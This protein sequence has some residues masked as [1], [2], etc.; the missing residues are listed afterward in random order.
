MLNAET[1]VNLLRLHALQR[2]QQT[3]LTFLRDGEGDAVSLTYAEL[4]LRARAI[5]SHLRLA[6]PN[7]QRALL[8]HPPG[9][10]FAAALCGCFYAGIT[11]VP[12]YPPSSK[13]GSR[14]GDRFLRL[15]ADAQVELV[16]TDSANLGRVMLQTQKLSNLHL[17]ATD[18]PQDLPPLP[19]GEDGGEGCPLRTGADLALI[20]YTSGSTGSPKGVML[21]HAN[22]MANLRTIQYSFKLGPDTRVVS[23]LPPY[24]DMGLIGGILSALACGYPLVMMAPQHFL[25]KPLRWLQAIDHYRA[26]TSGGP[27]FAFD[28][29][30]SQIPQQALDSL[31]LSCWTLAFCGAEPVRAATLQRFGQRFGTAGF[32]ASA[33]FPCY[34]L[35]EA[36]LM[37]TAVRRGEGAH[38]VAFDSATLTVG[39]A[40]R[41]AVAHNTTTLVSC[42]HAG[43]QVGLRIVNPHTQRV[44]PAG[45]VG[46]IWLSGPSM[47]AGYWQQSEASEATFHNTIDGENGA[48]WLRTG[49]L[50][51]LHNDELFINGRLKDIIIIRGRK[52]HPPDIEELATSSH[53]ALAL[54]ACAAFAVDTDTGEAL[55]IAA[56]IR[57]EARHALDAARVVRAIK[58]AVSETMAL[59]ADV[60]LLMPGA[61]ART[62]SGK[63]SRS[64][65]REQH[66]QGLWT[67]IP[68]TD[69]PHPLPAQH[70]ASA[71]QAKLFHH[72]ANVLR[73]PVD[74]L[75][76][77][78]SLG[79]LGLDSLK[80]VELALTLEQAFQV[81]LAQ[82]PFL[83]E[84]TLDELAALL[85]ART[86][87]KETHDASSP[88]SSPLS[89]GEDVH[90]LPIEI[91]ARHPAL[92]PG[93]CVPLTPLQHAYLYAGVAQ[94]ENFVQIVYLRTPRGLDCSALAHALHAVAARFDALRM[95]F[96][97]DT[98]GWLQVI[99][100][101]ETSLQFERIDASRLM[102]EQVRARR[103]DM[104]NQM[105]SGIDLANGPLVRAV[106]FERG[107]HETGVLGLAF[108][109]LVIDALSVSIFVT[110]LQYAYA[111]A[112]MGEPD[113]APGEPVFGRWLLSMDAYAQTTAPRELDYWCQVC[114]QAPSPPPDTDATTA[115]ATDTTDNGAD[116]GAGATASP[117]GAAGQTAAP[118]RWRRQVSPGLSPTANQQLLLRYPAPLQR[119]DLFLTA[120]AQAWCALSGDDHALVLLERHGRISFGQPA[121]MLAMGW[122]VCHYP[123]RIPHQPGMS[124]IEQVNRT[125][126]LM[127]EVPGDG[128]GYG[129]LLK[130][131]RDE[132]VQQAMRALRRPR[133]KLIYRGSIDDGF[134]ADATFPVIGSESLA[135]A[136]YDAQERSGDNCHAELYVSMIRGT[137]SWTL[138]YAPKFF[139]E[140]R[141]QA[142]LNEI[143]KLISAVTTQLD[144]AP[145]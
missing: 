104:V 94:P 135:Q 14:T 46:E 39:Q 49:D 77:A 90:P 75:D 33:F 79:A 27:G 44:C 124:A 19:P 89:I 6:R 24:H 18:A 8:L 59:S 111:Q 40:L 96:V 37:A 15:V 54:N 52:H 120:L 92:Q 87:D 63:I 22:L 137:V 106:L 110:A 126:R 1:L 17:L 71:T 62:T 35:A 133:L 72:I 57:R 136:Y 138:Q 12:S 43:T 105:R 45:T 99:G 56:E 21:S 100:E 53:P 11:A 107:A 30:M 42:G 13:L 32:H 2:P 108:H 101:L 113:V 109:H 55:L 121:P 95:R 29:C 140:I 65:C 91:D 115:A 16:L 80:H 85:Q 76:P 88:Q 67:P 122:F 64:A 58:T 66:L 78:S 41:V 132:A 116:A 103:A 3:A 112:L 129:L 9:L 83:P 130:T 102:P 23:W 119:H 139:D 10:E 82:A 125:Q 47:A 134:R 68:V 50:G 69:Q 117:P 81:S 128:V 7:A 31:D 74:S 61:L 98:S 51:F 70:A 73:V 131:C 114:G 143:D 118:P 28:L 4:D 25:Q 60:L 144:A 20:Q 142:L 127:A 34:G 93:Q 84:L 38:V 86:T 5:A 97:Q 48:P 123:V 141:A 26:N 145:G 36:T